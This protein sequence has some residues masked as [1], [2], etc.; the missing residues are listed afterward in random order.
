MHSTVGEG[1]KRTC[2]SGLL[3]VLGSYHNLII[4]VV[5]IKETEMGMSSQP[6]K[7]LID[8]RKGEMIFPHYYKKVIRRHHSDNVM[9]FTVV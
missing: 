8:E 6:L 7:H 9:E 1:A 2:E 3:L 4:A 5:P